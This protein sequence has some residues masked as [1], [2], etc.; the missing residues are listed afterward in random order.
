MF[1]LRNPTTVEAR[2]W[3]L[4][5]RKLGRIQAALSASMDEAEDIAQLVIGMQGGRFFDEIFSDATA[6]VRQPG[7]RLDDWFDQQSGTFGGRDALD[8]VRA[9]FG[10]VAR[11]DFGSVGGI[12]PRLDLP[13]LE[14]F[15]RNSMQLAE[16]RVTRGSDGLSVATPESWKRSIDIK[17]RYDGLVFDRDLAEGER[18]TR[19]LGVGHPLLDRALEDAASQPMLMGR[20]HGLAC[21]IVIAA[22]EDEITGTGST[23]HRV[24]VAAE[25]AGPTTLGSL[26]DWQALLRLNDLRPVDEEQ[27]PLPPGE[28]RAVHAIVSGLPQV[29]RKL[30]LPFR[31]AKATPLLCLLPESPRA[32]GT[33]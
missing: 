17:P 31:R 11:Y 10:N 2:I 15:F 13:A 7:E 6:V 26:F 21:P 3:A 16:R 27:V 22:V 5:E 12:I 19:L 24:M 4:L 33:P 28:R 29:V 25:S 20:V 18:M 9:M 14:Y 32:G 23:V 8:T 30:Q 1:L